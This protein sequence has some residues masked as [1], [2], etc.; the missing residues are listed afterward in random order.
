MLF[1]SERYLQTI[2]CKSI[3]FLI[4]LSDTETIRIPIKNW[5]MDKHGWKQISKWIDLQFMSPDRCFINWVRGLSRSWL[6][7]TGLL[8]R[9]DQCGLSDVGRVLD[10]VITWSFLT[11]SSILS[12][13]SLFRN[14]YVSTV[15]HPHWLPISL[16]HLIHR[17]LFF[18]DSRSNVLEIPRERYILFSFTPHIFL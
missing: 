13:S 6:W 3:N 18:I 1:C 9:L 4:D 15:V 11:I 14:N 16:V 8:N 2:P 10:K 12:W 5:W 7:V 17:Q